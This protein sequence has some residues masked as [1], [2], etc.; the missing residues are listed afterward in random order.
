MK[1]G[2]PGV[3]KQL[4]IELLEAGKD[5]R[6]KSWCRCELLNGRR[7]FY[8]SFEELFYML[9][10]IGAAEEEK[11][12]DPHQ[13]GARMVAEFAALATSHFPASDYA[14]G[15]LYRKISEWLNLPPKE[16]A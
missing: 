9:Q 4:K 15:E 3:T 10:F 8:P 2:T 13:K 12:P 11:Y 14:R 16:A 1:D 7:D 5:G 6:T